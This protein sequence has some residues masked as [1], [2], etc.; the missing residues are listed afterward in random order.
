MQKDKNANLR[1]LNEKFSSPNLQ[2]FYE[3]SM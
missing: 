1:K 2:M 3:T